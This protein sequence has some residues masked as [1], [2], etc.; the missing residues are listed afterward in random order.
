MLDGGTDP[1]VIGIN[2]RIA[3]GHDPSWLWDVPFERLAGRLVV[4]TGERCRDLAVRLRYAGVAHVTVRDDLEALGAAGAAR[5]EYVGNYTAFQDLRRHLARPG[6]SASRAESRRRPV[7]AGVPSA[8]VAGDRPRPGA[9]PAVA[10]TR[11]PVAAPSPG[12]SALRV[13]VVYPDLL[14][15]YGD[16]GN[17]RVLAGRAVWRGIAVEL[18]QAAVATRPFPTAPTSTA[19]A[20]GRTG[21]RCRRPSALRDGVLERRGGR[22]SGGLGRVRRLPGDRPV[23]PRRRR[24]APSRGGPA[25]RGHREGRRPPGR[26]G[27]GGRAPRDVPGGDADPVVLETSDRLREPRRGDPRRVRRR[28]PWPGCCPGVGQR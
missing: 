18:V 24:A 5:V 14:G 9:A 6:S 23:V 28:D 16:G 13:V 7:G 4:A 17:G 2:A 10:V 22:R 21:P 15:T 20:A 1:V 12:P 27:A 25:R 3:D 8:V 26:G 19:S 11:R